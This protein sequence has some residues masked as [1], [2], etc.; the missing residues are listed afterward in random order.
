LFFKKSQELNLGH[1]GTDDDLI[2]SAVRLP[3]NLRKEN[4]INDVENTHC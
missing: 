4:A 3:H 1:D 2:N